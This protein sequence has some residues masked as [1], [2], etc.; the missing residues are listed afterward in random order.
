MIDVQELLI[1]ID[2]LYNNDM[3]NKRI[4]TEILNG[5]KRH[6]KGFIIPKSYIIDK[7]IN[8]K[9]IND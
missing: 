7:S 5:V 4:C 6:T 8:I 3:I 1:M 9:V 2:E